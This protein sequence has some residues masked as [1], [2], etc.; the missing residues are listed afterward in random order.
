MTQSRREELSCAGIKTESSF[1]RVAMRRVNGTNAKTA[2][3]EAGAALHKQGIF[4]GR[5]PFADAAKAVTMEP[6]N[7]VWFTPSSSLVL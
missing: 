7:T 5:I 4:P 2:S 6:C 3:R 1:V